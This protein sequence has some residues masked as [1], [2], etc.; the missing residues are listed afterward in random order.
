MRKSLT[1]DT[2]PEVYARIVEKLK[3]AGRTSGSR[4]TAEQTGAA[5]GT[6]VNF[7][8]ASADRKDGRTTTAIGL[9]AATA[10]LKPRRRV[11]LVDLDHRNPAI[12]SMLGLRSKEPSAGFVDV[13]HGEAGL[14]EVARATSVENLHV[15]CRSREALD[16]PDDCRSEAMLRELSKVRSLYDYAFFDSPALNDHVDAGLLSEVMDSV[17]LVIRSDRSG[18]DDVLRA[19]GSIPEERLAGAVLNDFRNPVPSFIARH[20]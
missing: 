4:D 18:K 13:L 5:T 11:L 2:V 14:E 17:L 3:T 12:D 10:V 15:V 20:L 9:A 19:K 7:L 1:T 6:D 16:V 8:V